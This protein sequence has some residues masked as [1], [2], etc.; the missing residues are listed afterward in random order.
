MIYTYE[1]IK[2]IFGNYNHV[3]KQIKDKKLFK[4]SHGLYTNESPHLIELETIF[5]TYPNAILSLESAFAYYELSDYV[6]NVY[7]ICTS[8]K[9][10]KIKNDKVK[11]IYISD[12]F[13][14]IGKTVIKTKDGQINI[15]DKERLLIELIRFKKRFSL[16]YY[17]QVVNAYRELYKNDE[18]NIQKIVLYCK[19]IRWGQEIRRQIMEVVL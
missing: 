3:Q 6:P 19:A 15:Y 12:D 1:E 5:A 8:R 16:D 18:L 14:N 7:T 10:H 4:V 13:L 9:A 2:K 11:Q 17:K